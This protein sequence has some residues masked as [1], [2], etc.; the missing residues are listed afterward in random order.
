[1][2]KFGKHI[3]ADDTVQNLKGRILLETLVI[4]ISD[5]SNITREILKN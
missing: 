5:F 4:E 2:S 3:I 1:M